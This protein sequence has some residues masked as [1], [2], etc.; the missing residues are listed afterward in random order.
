M[1]GVKKMQNLIDSYLKWL[2]EN[3]ILKQIEE[4]TSEKTTLL[5]RHNNYI[6]FYM[7]KCKDGSIY[8]TDDGYT[9]SDLESSGFIFNT[10]KRKELLNNI[11]L[12]YHLE[13]KDDCII[14]QTS[15]ENFPFRKHFFIQGIISINDLFFTNKNNVTSLFLEDVN[16]FFENEEVYY[17]ENIK[18]TGKSGFDHTIDYVFPGMKKRNITEKYIKI[19]NSPNK[20]NTESVIFMQN[21]LKQT[22][23]SDN[24]MFVLINDIDNPIKDGVIQAYNNYDIETLRWSKKDYIMNRIKAV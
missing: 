11:L 21:D 22:R 18:I 19:I 3:I 23:K 13:L 5:N 16:S 14:T 7:K 12:N 6:Q 8:L 15:E 20:T 9:I 10:K 2:K 17:N 1:E 24:E 4:Y